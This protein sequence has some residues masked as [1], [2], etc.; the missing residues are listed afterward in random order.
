MSSM[1]IVYFLYPEAFTG[2]MFAFVGI[3]LC[4]LAV[5]AGLYSIFRRRRD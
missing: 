2:E 3:S 5:G 1:P 4:V